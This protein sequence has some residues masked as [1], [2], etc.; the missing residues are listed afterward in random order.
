MLKCFV[1]LKSFPCALINGNEIFVK[2]IRQ[3]L[4]ANDCWRYFMT[5]EE[6]ADGSLGE[7]TVHDGS[8]MTDNQL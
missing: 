8:D 1:I 3:L 5:A 6:D 2:L 7:I 4:K